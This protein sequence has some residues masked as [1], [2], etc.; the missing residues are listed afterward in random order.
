MTRPVLV[1]LGGLPGVGKTTL[2]RNLAPHFKATFLRVDSIEQSIV[3]SSLD[4]ED[5]AEAGYM[6][7]FRVAKD[8]LRLGTS[9]IADSVNPIA[10]SRQSWRDC[11]EESGCDLVEIELICSDP[12][13]HQ[14]RIETREADISRLKL[15]EWQDVLERDYEDWASRSFV[16]DTAGKTPQEI[17]DAALSGIEQALIKRNGEDG[18]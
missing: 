12:A 10:L 9:V 5:C 18:E 14:N 1:I 7:G 8:N 11:A 2:A 6:V 16:I 3:N 4:I 17:A 13:E 15:P